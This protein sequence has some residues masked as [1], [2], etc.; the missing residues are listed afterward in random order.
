[1]LELLS[2]IIN[3]E[4]LSVSVNVIN[5]YTNNSHEYGI[6][7]NQILAGRYSVVLPKRINQVFIIEALNFILQNNYFLFDDT[8]YRQ[9]WERKQ[10]LFLR[11]W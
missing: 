10:F 5:I 1:M 8:Y 2:K 9:Q 11:T 7:S 6:K 3:E 4:V